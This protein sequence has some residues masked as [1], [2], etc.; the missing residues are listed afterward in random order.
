MARKLIKTYMNTPY[1]K[2]EI[3]TSKRLNLT[4]I[5]T[6]VKYAVSHSLFILMEAAKEHVDARF[7]NVESA[8]RVVAGGHKLY[9]AVHKMY[10]QSI[11]NNA[12]IDGNV[13]RFGLFDTRIL[14]EAVEAVD[15]KKDPTPWWQIFEYG[16]TQRDS[17]FSISNKFLTNDSRVF[18]S[19]TRGF[20]GR[21][22]GEKAFKNSKFSAKGY[23]GEG[24]LATPKMTE[25]FHLKHH[26][27]VVPVRAI[28]T[29]IPTVRIFITERLKPTIKMAIVEALRTQ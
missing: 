12:V 18:G 29:F 10:T 27:G 22:L 1:G 5:K 26:P 16:S 11:T 24:I 4:R 28:S 19:S 15:G 21:K 3:D 23:W 2:I 6:A 8:G 17:E 7:S 25:V 9:P 14:N 20:L 13:I